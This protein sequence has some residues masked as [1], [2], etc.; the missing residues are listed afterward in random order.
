MKF[1]KP[2]LLISLPLIVVLI[3]LQ[4]C[5]INN[6]QL[7]E[8]EVKKITVIEITEGTSFDIVFKENGTSRYYINRGLEQGLTIEDL[9]EKVLNKKVT[10]HLP[11]LFYGTSQH[12]AQ[13]AVEDDVIFT[14]FD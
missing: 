13:L 6:P 4:G 10:L 7:D 1:F 12:I 9:R 3:M 14:E 2:F 5:I 11:K 8:C